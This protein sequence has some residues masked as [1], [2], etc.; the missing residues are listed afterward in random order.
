MWTAFLVS[1]ATVQ[2]CLLLSP[3]P[4][5][6]L[7]PMPHPMLLPLSLHS[8]HQSLRYLVILWAPS[9]PSMVPLP[10]PGLV[11]HQLQL[12]FQ[13]VHPAALKVPSQINNHSQELHHRQWSQH[14]N[15]QNQTKIH[16]VWNLP[17]SP[18]ESTQVRRCMMSSIPAMKK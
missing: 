14:H 3:M 16:A 9:V 11:H 8:F 1:K 15:G 17:T 4:P 10:W 6:M 5:L 2:I 7:P 12:P 13:L 18:G